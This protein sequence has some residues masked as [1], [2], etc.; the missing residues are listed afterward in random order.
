MV[1]LYYLKYFVDACDSGSLAKAA[2]LNL[3]SSSAI[4]QSIKWLEDYYQ[5][6]LIE[7]GK[8]KFIV[9]QIGEEVVKR[10]REFLKEFGH[11]DNDIKKMGKNFRYVLTIS[12]QQS[13]AKM[14]LKIQQR[15]PS[16]NKK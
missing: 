14:I 6:E 9:T 10:T 12:M 11:F 16:D 13:I 15:W 8:N 3:V 5:V 7:H 4:S 2:Q 1:N